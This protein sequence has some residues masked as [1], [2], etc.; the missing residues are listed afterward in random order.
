[1]NEFVESKVNH[2]A[3]AI[4]KG[5]D[6]KDAHALGELTFYMAI[7]RVLKGEATIQDLG[8]MDAINDI[9]QEAKI[10]E[11]SKTF[12]SLIK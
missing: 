1:M 3:E 4:L 2:Y 9:L 5:S 10:I 7:R 11:E 6:K 8:M 12:T